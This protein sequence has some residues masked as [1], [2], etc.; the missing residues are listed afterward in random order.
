MFIVAYYTYEKRKYFNLFLKDD[1]VEPCLR[2]CGSE[3]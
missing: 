2:P 1:T 3:F